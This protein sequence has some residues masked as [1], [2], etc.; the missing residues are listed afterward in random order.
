MIRHSLLTVF[1]VTVIIAICA[2]STKADVCSVSGN[3]VN[4]CGFEIGNFTGWTPSG[5]GNLVDASAGPNSGLFHGIFG[6]GQLSQSIATV[7]GTTYTV[8]FFLRNPNSGVPNSFSA[9]FGST[10]LLT[11]TDHA[12]FSYTFYT[13]SV[14]AVGSSTNLDF[15]FLHAQSDW[16]IDDI[17]VVA[18]PEPATMLLLGTGLLGVTASIRRRRKTRL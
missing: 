12:S 5:A 15:T 10:S 4:N 11:L 13:F 16:L 7:P 6:L 14:V 8:S 1:F 18:V 17:V 2:S 3:L 9:S